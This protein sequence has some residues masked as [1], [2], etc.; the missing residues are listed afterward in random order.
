MSRQVFAYAAP[1]ACYVLFLALRMQFGTDAAFDVRWLYGVQVAVVSVLLLACARQYADLRGHL[2][3]APVSALSVL[4]GIAVFI[5]WIN[6]DA[7][8]MKLGE[9]AGYSPLRQ[10]G[11]VDPWLAVVRACGAAL[12][13]PVMEE[14]FWRSFLMRW[15][16]DRDFGGIDPRKIGWT[17]LVAVSLVFG[18]EHDLWLAGV[19]AGLAYGYLYMRTASLWA[20]VI[21]HA[22]TNGLLALWVL[23]G[24]RWEYW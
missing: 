18:L 6:L 21:A 20:P 17:P 15:M 14:L 4:C 11:R 10:D 22:V 5:V 19:I 1:F 23:A 24:G 13:V 2:P 8:W 12:V 9:S 7:S 3:T 16:M